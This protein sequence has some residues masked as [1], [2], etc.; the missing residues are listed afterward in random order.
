MS[1]NTAKHLV[2]SGALRD[3]TAHLAQASHSRELR[4]LQYQV[5]PSLVIC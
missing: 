5:C 2:M 3:Q 4:V 1:S